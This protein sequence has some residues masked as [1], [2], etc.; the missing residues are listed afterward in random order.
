[1]WIRNFMITGLATIVWFAVSFVYM[2][3]LL[4]RRIEP[5][6]RVL[7]GLGGGGALGI[8]LLLLAIYIETKI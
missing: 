1:M 2:Y 4:P 7:W 8:T 6:K 5:A 3:S